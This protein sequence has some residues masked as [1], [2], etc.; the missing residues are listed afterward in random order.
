MTHPA[1]LWMHDGISEREVS[2]RWPDG[3]WDN[4]AWE[5]CT[6]DS[7]LMWY[8]MSYDA[9]RPSTHYEAERLRQASGEDPIGG[10]NPFDVRRGIQ[11]R[12][13]RTVAQAIN[14]WPTLK[15]AMG[16]GYNGLVSGSM[17]AFPFGHRLRRPQ[18]GFAA[19]H[20]VH[21]A[22]V[23]SNPRY[24]VTN[25]LFA[26]DHDGE[27]WSEDELRR[28]VQAL[29]GGYHLVA[30]TLPRPVV[31]PPP[32]A[33]EMVRIKAGGYFYDYD[34]SGTATGGYTIKRT[35]RFTPGGF[36]AKLG[37]SR[38]DIYWQGSRRLFAKII[39]KTS[40]YDGTWLDL[41]A[42]GVIVQPLED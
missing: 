21:A 8:R 25:P 16:V 35:Q 39:D 26:E 24:W 1:A 3:Q 4:S 30:K 5:D 9:T 38:I 18:P 13:G 32:P 12:Y 27:W 36:S 11:A 17:A 31:V 42:G 28:F 20:A 2:H 10:T 37:R 33:L 41:L 29:P 14:G 40:A 23:D 15:L 7:A 22:K 34:I 19:P 6:F